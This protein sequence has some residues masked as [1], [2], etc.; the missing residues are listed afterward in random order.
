[1]LKDPFYRT[2]CTRELRVRRSCRVTVSF[3]KLDAYLRLCIDLR[4]SVLQSSNFG[5]ARYGLV[6]AAE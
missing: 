4:A 6:S 1:M 2:E 3:V 5:S